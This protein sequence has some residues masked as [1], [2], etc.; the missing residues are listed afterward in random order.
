YY[1]M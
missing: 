1:K